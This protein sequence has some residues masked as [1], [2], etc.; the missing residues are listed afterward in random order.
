MATARCSRYGPAL[1]QFLRQRQICPDVRTK[2][3]YDLY[4]SPGLGAAWRA[5]L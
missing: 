4:F 5:G 2:A 1:V 3:A